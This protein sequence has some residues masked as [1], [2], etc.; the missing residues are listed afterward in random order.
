MESVINNVLSELER[1]NENLLIVLKALSELQE[2]ESSNLTVQDKLRLSELSIDVTT[3]MIAVNHSL[4]SIP[5]AVK[6]AKKNNHERT[7]EQ[8]AK[9]QSATLNDYQV[10]QKKIHPIA[11][12]LRP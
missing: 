7:I 11:H 12:L 5:P 1:I 2:R 6:A 3:L 10:I 4:L 9:L 8:L